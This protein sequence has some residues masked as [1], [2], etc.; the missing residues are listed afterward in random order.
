[1]K[2]WTRKY[3]PKSLEEYIG[4]DYV[5]GNIKA[6]IS[7]DKLP[8]TLLFEGERGTGKTSMARLLAKAIMCETP[9]NGSSCNTCQTCSRFDE[10]L[11]TGVTPRGLQVYEYDITKV[12]RRDDA[13]VIVD[14]MTARVVGRRKRVYILDEIQ[15]ATPEA[16]S[17][18]LKI[19][20][21]PVEDLYIIL[22]TT[23]P[24]DL[25]EALRSRF[26][27]FTIRKPDNASIVDRLSYICG[28]EGVNYSKRGLS[29]LADTQGNNPRESINKAE[30]LGMTGD[31]TLEKVEQEMSLVNTTYYTTFLKGA[32]EGNLI[33]VVYIISEIQSRGDINVSQFTDG[34][35]QYLAELL[36]I[37]SGVKVDRYSATELTNKRKELKLYTDEQLISLMQVVSKYSNIREGKEYQLLAMG[38]DVMEALKVE[39]TPAVEEISPTE[40]GVAYAETTAEVKRQRPA[41]KVAVANEDTLLSIFGNNIKK[42]R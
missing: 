19:A 36:K 22:C 12:N 1:M 38:I 32:L 31:I 17:T 24:E 16:Q 5:K 8:P 30:L 3:R 4:N 37:R 26:H 21:E 40:A 34:L 27:R 23:H 18:F 13:T 14:R 25:L 9:V 33:R 7:R 6:L 2:S 28:E 42:L 35:G 39:E 15:R 10:Y 11:E 41:K 29:L 20:E